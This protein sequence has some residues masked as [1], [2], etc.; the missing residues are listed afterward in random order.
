MNFFTLLNGGERKKTLLTPATVGKVLPVMK[1]T[2]TSSAKTYYG[3]VL[4]ITENNGY[5][6]SDFFAI[7]WDE[8]DQSVK[9]ISDGTT[10]FAA[11]AK[12]HKADASPEVRAK[13][14][15]WLRTVH[16]PPL[17]KQSLIKQ[18]TSLAN[19]Q[20]G[21]QVAIV[22]GRKYPVG[23]KGE[24][25][26]VYDNQ[27]YRDYSRKGW[28]IQ[29]KRFD[30]KSKNVGIRLSDGSRIFTSL[31]NVERLSIAIPT[32]NEIARE[33]NSLAS[34]GVQSIFSG[35]FAFSLYA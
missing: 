23:T 7:V 1:D 11:P 2:T 15:N 5:N 34:R 10:R 6:D 29:I 9:S 20:F 30:P 31:A 32:E 13:A 22:K 26:G 25:F 21:E 8:E 24:V 14:D 35:W 19:L 33:A 16:L 4:A 12:Y 17:A 3:S 18:R 28:A 27:F